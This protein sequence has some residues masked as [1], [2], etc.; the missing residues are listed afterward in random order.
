MGH[1]LKE[2]SLLS[3]HPRTEQILC[4][5]E[6]DTPSVV[7]QRVASARARSNQWATTAL[8]ERVQILQNLYSILANDAKA[9]AITLSEEVGRP[10]QESLG[11]EVIPSLEA[12][13]F[14]IRS[15]KGLLKPHAIRHSKA[16]VFPEPYGVIGLIGTWNYPLFLN[17]VPICQALLAGNCV[18]WKPS[19]LALL[20]AQKMFSL[21][22]SAGVPE[23]VFEMVL[24]GKE[25]GRLLTQSDCD[26]YV[27]TG[28]VPTGRAI[29]AEV[30]QAGKPCVM[31]LSG[32]DAFIVCADA[33][34]EVAACSA[35]WGRVCNAGQSCIS[36]QR[37][38]VVESVYDSFLLRV[39]S[40]I[41]GLKREE[42]TPLR[43]KAARDHCHHLVEK[44]VRQGARC[45]VGGAFDANEVG[46]FYPPTLLAECEDH[47]DVM[48]ED[49]FAPIIAVCPVRNEA[50]AIERANEA[51]LGLGASIWTRDLGRGKA[52]AQKLKVGLVSL[53]E[54]LLDAAHPAIPF[55]G[56]K[57]S[58]F[59]KQRGALGFEEFVVRKVVSNHSVK[60]SRKHLFPYLKATED[61]LLMWISVRYQRRWNHLSR[62]VQ[63]A[64]E[65]QTEQRLRKRQ[66]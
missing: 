49:L 34:L 40:E 9:F 24:G 29:L 60:K 50:E 54:V 62:V 32:N 10:V 59:G 55:G 64:R 57:Q 52:L 56:M 31:E 18:V 38:Y 2:A 6:P 39:E 1:F 20:S 12:L 48:R 21:F 41:R 14:L 44:A 15:A 42:L 23:G 16:Q 5:V 19:E 36:P 46:F 43:T 3:I 17:I 53:N 33:P 7:A 13:Q 45:C 37:F 66:P 11:A 35:V 65:W 28:S 61:L 4:I 26:K 47:F 30:A 27:F 63:F 58:G 22:R 51:T 25:V 8:P